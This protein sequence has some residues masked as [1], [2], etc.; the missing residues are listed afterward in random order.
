MK[1]GDFLP[2]DTPPLERALVLAMHED[3]GEHEDPPGSNRGRYPDLVNTESGSPLGSPW[4]AN[5]VAHNC[6]RVGIRVPREAGSCDAWL[7]MAFERGRA[8][9]EAKA[10]YIVIYGVKND[11]RPFGWDAN[12]LAVVEQVVP[13]AFPAKARVIEIGGNTT[14]VPGFDR[15]GWIMQQKPVDAARL[16]CYMKPEAK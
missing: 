14:L 7:R 10:G 8:T 2:A 12:H 9:S 5:A 3:L 4:C 15:E 13:M 16:I 11:R 6:R 1:P